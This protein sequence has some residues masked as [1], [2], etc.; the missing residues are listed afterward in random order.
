MKVSLIKSGIVENIVEVASL[1]QAVKLFP[2]YTCLVALNEDIGDSR[3]GAVVTKAPKQPR[4]LSRA[5]YFELFTDAELLAIYTAAPTS[6]IVR[7]YLAR[8]DSQIE[9]DLNSKQ[10]KRNLKT[11]VDEN[12]LTPARRTEIL[13]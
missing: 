13:S 8:I 11:L 1:A 6:P 12:L 9:I 5:D 3:A 10:A 2:A 7:V 4:F